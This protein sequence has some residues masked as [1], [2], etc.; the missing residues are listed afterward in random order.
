MNFNVNDFI[1]ETPSLST[2]AKEGQTNR[3]PVEVFPLPVQ[4]II[5][6][7]NENLNFPID[8]IGPSLLYAVSVTV[9]NTHRVEVKKGWLE[10]SVLYLSIVA[11]A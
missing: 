4:Q 1:D 9:G 7:T 5:T 3:F 10:S 6:A 2:E 8:F 11:R